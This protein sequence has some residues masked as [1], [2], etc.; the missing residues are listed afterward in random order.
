MR[1]LLRLETESLA[2][3]IFD[4]LRQ[5]VAVSLVVPHGLSKSIY[6]EWDGGLFSYVEHNDNVQTWNGKEA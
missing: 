3:S 4:L 6:R 1:K 5:V 2:Q